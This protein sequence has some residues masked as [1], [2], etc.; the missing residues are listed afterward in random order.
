MKE[1]LPVIRS[2]GLFCGIS[3]EELSAMLSCLDTRK[4]SF[5]KDSFLLRVGDTEE[6]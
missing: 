4:R 6:S 3:E 5:P 2:S 1:F